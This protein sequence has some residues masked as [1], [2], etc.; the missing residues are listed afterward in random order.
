MKYSLRPRYS[1]AALLLAVTGVSVGLGILRYLHHPPVYPIPAH[2]GGRTFSGHAF[3][4]RYE[5]EVTQASMDAAPTWDRHR[6]NPPLSANEAMIRA[7][8]V[9]LRLIRQKKLRDQIEIDGSWQ[10]VAAELTPFDDNAGQ[11]YWLVHFEYEMARSGSPNE[12]RL[13]VL[14]DGTVPEPS[15]SDY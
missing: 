4:R 15:V 7:D 9:R 3:G 1:L 12:L 8:Q 10:L 14:M 13:I 2:E 5:V 11:W 6:A